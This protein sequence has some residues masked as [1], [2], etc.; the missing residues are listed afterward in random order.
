MNLLVGS[1]GFVGSNLYESGAFEKGVHS[2]NVGEAF[3]LCPELLVYAGVRAEKYLA[4]QEPKRDLEQ[5]LQAEENIRKIAPKRLVLISTIDVFSSPKLVDE[6]TPVSREGLH[7]YGANRYELECWAREYDP[8]CLIVRLP[9]LYGKNIKKNFI[10]D[11][12]RVIP[13]ML[14]ESKMEQLKEQMP[15]LEQYY[16][17]RENGFWQ[18]QRQTEKQ[19]ELLRE[20]FRQAGFTALNFTDSRSRFQ[21]YPLSRLWQDLCVAMENHLKLWHPATE[22]VLAGEIY[23]ELMGER[24]VN[25]LGGQPADYD[26]R[27]RYDS[28]YQGKGGYICTKSEILQSIK[29]SVRA[30][31]Y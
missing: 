4:N 24:F 19:E 3:G 22:P 1:T 30:Y 8:D 18:Y 6:D 23:E 26:Y 11:L 12:I 28:L 15:N 13:S 21:F 17:R 29:E 16:V 9:G 25:E 14:S 31:R 2:S 10:Y 7:A 20:M 5:I 27:T